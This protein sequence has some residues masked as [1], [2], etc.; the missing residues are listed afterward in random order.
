VLGAVKMEF[1]K[2]GDIIAKVK[3]KL[4]EASNTIDKVDVRTRAITRKLREV[5]D[6]P[7]A[8]AEPLIAALEA[9]TDAEA[10]SES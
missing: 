7:I 10:N 3:D 4:L 5:E 9:E 6:L 8:A 1:S 2:F